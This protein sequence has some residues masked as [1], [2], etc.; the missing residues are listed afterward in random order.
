MIIYF[1]RSVAPENV[2]FRGLLKGR[3]QPG[4]F[5]LQKEVILVAT[6]EISMGWHFAVWFDYFILNS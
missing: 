4:G 2:F 5:F 6:G 3:E 1:Y